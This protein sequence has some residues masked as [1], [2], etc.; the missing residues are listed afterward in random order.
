MHTIIRFIIYIYKY[1]T[2]VY[3]DNHFIIIVT[4]SYFVSFHLLQYAYSSI[5]HRSSYH[6]IRVICILR[7]LLSYRVLV[8]ANTLV[9]IV[10]YDIILSRMYTHMYMHNTSHSC[11]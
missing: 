1:Y 8:L 5:F 9:C 2:L 10:Y 6:I 4:C 7:V 11:I 3:T